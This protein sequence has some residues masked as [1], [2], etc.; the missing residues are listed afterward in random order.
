M[1]AASKADKKEPSSSTHHIHPK[2]KATT[3]LLE[4]GQMPPL[5][6]QG[7][8][9]SLS[10]T[11]S[12]PPKSESINLHARH[13]CALHD[14]MTGRTKDRK[15]DRQKKFPSLPK[16]SARSA[17]RRP[18]SRALL[19]L[20][21]HLSKTD[22]TIGLHPKCQPNLLQ[23][24]SFTAIRQSIVIS[25]TNRQHQNTRQY[26]HTNIKQTYLTMPDLCRVLTHLEHRKRTTSRYKHSPPVAHPRRDRRFCRADRP[27]DRP[28][29]TRRSSTDTSARL[30]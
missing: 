9:H 27:T 5:N 7:G 29:P 16:E 26:T 20:H 11:L 15:I 3:L 28:K 21:S 6:M 1:H 22:R 24:A 2:L 8:R 30:A 19:L 10:C 25:P 12:P 18:P 17:R 13:T 23:W 4:T 14:P